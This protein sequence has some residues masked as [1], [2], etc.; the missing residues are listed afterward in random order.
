MG[1]LCGHDHVIVVRSTP[2]TDRGKLWLIAISSIPQE[3]KLP[4]AGSLAR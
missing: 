3:K 4:G 2:A 1:K